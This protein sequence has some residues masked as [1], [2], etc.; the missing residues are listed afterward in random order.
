MAT[1]DFMAGKFSGETPMERFY[2]MARTAVADVVR[3]GGTFVLVA[4]ET[5][6][7][8]VQRPEAEDF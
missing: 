8:M 5:K 2:F 3:N 7:T 4:S 6:L 1:K